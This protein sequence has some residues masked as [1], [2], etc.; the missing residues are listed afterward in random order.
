MANNYLTVPQFTQMHDVRELLDLSGDEN[1]H[2]GN[3]DNIQ[4]LLDQSASELD[5]YL[6]GRVALPL[7]S[8]PAICG[9][10]VGALTKQSMFGRRADLPAG[11]KAEIDWAQ[12]WLTK[13]TK[14]IVKLPSV[15]PAQIPT[16][17]D[18]D[19]TDGRSRFDT[20]FGFVPSPTGPS[21]GL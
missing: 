3:L 15:T 14:G 2:D 16:L 7:T 12:D 6:D 18:S 1:S 13:F 19:Y 10:I 21:K 17:Q 8:P 5:S 9:K 4:L 11:V 20:A